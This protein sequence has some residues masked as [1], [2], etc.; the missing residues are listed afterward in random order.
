[1]IEG[2]TRESCDKAILDP[3]RRQSVDEKHS[4]DIG[5]Y[6]KRVKEG[7]CFLCEL[8]AGTNPHHLIYKGCSPFQTRKWRHLLAPFARP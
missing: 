3:F 5:A 6:E 7:P 1:M 2:G 8:V 4:V